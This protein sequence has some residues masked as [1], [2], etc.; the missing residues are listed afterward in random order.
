M[1][2]FESGRPLVYVRSAEEDRVG[3]LLRNAGRQL[4][5]A[6]PLPLWTWS[7]TEGLTIDEPEAQAP[8]RHPRKA[9][10][11]RAHD[12]REALDFIAMHADPAIFH[13][14]DFHEPLRDSASVRRRVRDL[15]Q[16]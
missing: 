15:Y 12:P 4:C 11:A 7:L 3:V 1:D 10:E 5:P 14:K 9:A 16:L 6:K 8:G 13:L 2:T